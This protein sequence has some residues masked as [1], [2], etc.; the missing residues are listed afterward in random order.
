M[1]RLQVPEEENL[2][3]SQKALRDAVVGSR[4][5]LGP[6]VWGRGPFG[7]WQNAPNVGHP[8][9]DLGAAVRFGTSLAA[10]AREV[11]ICAVG[12]HYKAKF[13]FAAHRAIGIEAGLSA[14]ALDLLA[15]GEDP[16]WSG[17][18]DLVHRYTVALLL[19]H[20]VSEELHQEL[21]ECVSESGAVELVTTI[22]YYCLI[23]LTLNAFEVP[24]SKEMEDPWPDS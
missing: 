24:L 23:C 6:E 13:E 14:N 20:R 17:D 5:G 10:D 9:L 12:V 16:G 19:D 18:L 4:K 7:V 3:Q 2:D 11:A 1:S 22:G 15:A 21:V 8:A